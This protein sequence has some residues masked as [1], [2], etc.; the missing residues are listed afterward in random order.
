MLAAVD[1]GQVQVRFV[2]EGRQRNVA[3]RS[4]LGHSF[5]ERGGHGV[6]DAGQHD[7]L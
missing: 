3:Q 4:Q 7:L 1:V 5:V 6:L 2:Q